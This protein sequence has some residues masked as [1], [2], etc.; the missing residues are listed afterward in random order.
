M[1]LTG[2]PEP[3]GRAWPRA[4]RP[5]LSLESV[6]P[7][8]LILLGI[9]SVQVGAA[10]AKNLFAQIS[11]TAIVMLRLLTSAVVL[12]VVSRS[13]LRDLTRRHSWADIGVAAL[14]GLNLAAM[15]FSFY[16]ALARIP[17]GVAV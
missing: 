16:Q 4:F 3:Y 13:A 6:P 7:P 2:A 15:N 17:L 9:V 11:P 10:L 1:A 8:A 5:R 14:F 12:S